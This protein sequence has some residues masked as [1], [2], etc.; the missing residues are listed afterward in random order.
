MAGVLLSKTK[1]LNGLQCLKYLWLAVNEPDRVPEPDSRTQHLFDQGHLVEQLAR[2]LFPEGREVPFD[3]F[4][5][6]IRRTQEL[7]KE[8]RPLF[9]GGITADNL[10]SRLDVLRPAD[11]GK[12]DIVEVKSSTKV[13]DEN[14]HDI[15]F[16]KH[17]C[18]KQGLAINSCYLIYINNQYVRSGE[19][20][21]QQ[22]FIMEDV[23]G[24]V[25]SAGIGIEYRIKT[26]LKTIAARECP[27][28]PVGTHCSNPYD[29]PITICHDS[30]PDNNILDLYR[31]GKK[32]F[33]LLYG[34]ILRLRDIPETTRL[35]DAQKVQKWCDANS[36]CYVDSESIKS[37]LRKLEYPI[38]YLDFETFN[39]AVPLFDGIRP[40]QHVPFQF[41]LHI[42]ARPGTEPQH[43]SYL[44]DGS[45]DPRP[46]FI[47]QLRKV[48]GETG[49]IVVYN[50]SFEQGRLEDLGQ[51]F[52]EYRPWVGAVCSRLVDLM[53]PFRD[54]DYYHP[55]QKG[56]ASLKAVLP[57]LTGKS[58]DDLPINNGDDASLAYL[59]MTYDTMPEPEKEELRADLEEYC[60]LDTQ[61]MIWIVDRLK[62]VT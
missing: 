58:Y 62:D 19:I 32:C 48:I 16:Q 3:D 50:Q 18:E 55:D 4:Q 37:F 36:C 9:Q 35:S 25:T 47:S 44:S 23:T 34:G 2:R 52:P 46:E 57:A 54:F 43:F 5:T 7:L 42:V 17:C 31:G 6:N 51:A 26:M 29:C 11:K 13:K 60:G 14:L 10:Y 53:Q 22:L 28:S 39:T 59:S 21:P 15:S 12:W 41:S 8:R 49:S 38:H 1:Y 20:D 61:G 27:D 40:Y 24:L 33:D 56:S 45:E 30:L